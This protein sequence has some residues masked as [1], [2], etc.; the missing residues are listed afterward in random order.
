[1]DNNEKFQIEKVLWLLNL[2]VVQALSSNH[3]TLEEA[4]RLTFSPNMLNILKSGNFNLSL[5][6]L[7]HRGTEL[8]DL[9][10]NVRE[11]E[12][13]LMQA[14]IVNELQKM[15]PITPYMSRWYAALFDQV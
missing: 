5:I 10:G 3:I 4:E 8:E 1:M 15:Q 6:D 12:L 14:M 2:G 9:R 11:N 13:V 7:I